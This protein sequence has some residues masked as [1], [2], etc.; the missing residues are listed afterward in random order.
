MPS[1]WQRPWMRELWPRAAWMIGLGTDG[2]GADHLES[3]GQ[4]PP[5]VPLDVRP[6]RTGGAGF[7]G[8]C[9]VGPEKLELLN[10]ACE[11]GRC[12]SGSATEF[13]VAQR[14]SGL[15]RVSATLTRAKK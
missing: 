12:H 8:P 11:I 2:A 13:A 10:V 9:G 1:S 14:P 3:S 15:V 6:R 7:A 5:L 4:C